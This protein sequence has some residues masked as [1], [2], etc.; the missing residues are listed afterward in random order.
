[1]ICYP[2]LWIVIGSNPFIPTVMEY[3]SMV[4]P[5]PYKAV[6]IGSTPIEPVIHCPMI[7]MV[8][9]ETLNLLFSVQLRVGLF[10]FGGYIMSRSYD[11]IMEEDEHWG[12]PNKTD[13]DDMSEAE[14]KQEL[15]DLDFEHD[16][17][18]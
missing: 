3:S 14:R 15:I 4:E 18:T 16:N 8:S 11:E 13:W 17:C 10:F 12:E 7:E 5:R 2:V 6:V 1:M 9:L